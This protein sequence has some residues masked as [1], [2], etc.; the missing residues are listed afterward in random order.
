M[1]RIFTSSILSILLCTVAV[2]SFANWQNSGNYIPGG[3]Y[4]ADDGARFVL[5][6]RGGAAWGNAKI[7]NSLTG[8]SAGYYYDM[9][10]GAAITSA[11]W[12]CYLDGKP[13]CAYSN[14][15]NV[16]FAGYG[17]VGALG[18][19]EKYSKFSF[20]GGASI[21]FT[22]PNSPQWRMEA[23]WDHIAE[24]EYNQSPLFS[25]DLALYGGEIDGVV[26]HAE[27]ASVQSSLTTDVFSA[28]AFYDFYSGIQKP[29]H[30][31]IPYVGFG[32]GYGISRSDLSVYDNYG[33]LSSIDG[34]ADYGMV[35]ENYI[36]S[37]NKS[38]KDISNF[39]ALAALGMSYGIYENTFLD[40]GIR[41]MYI[42][43]IE[44]KLIGNDNVQTRNL[45]SAKN[46]I[47][48]D[49]MFGLR[50]EF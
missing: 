37:F 6:V 50:I 21:G 32:V 23:G 9:S 14:P 18:A 28:M 34:M 31:V 27:M 11:Y 29:L 42:P 35:G 24:A 8:A 26:V 22:I 30:Q 17:D 40:F 13:G 3:V 2:P 7:E 49:F 45:F 15:E 1:E 33:D 38:S 4:S 12:Q 48:T 5:S 19:D 46:M 47:Y 39:V 44:W 20:A 41:A 36:I 10:N 25:G 43:S 16:Y